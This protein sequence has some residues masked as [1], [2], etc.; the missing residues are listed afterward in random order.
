MAGPL[1]SPRA[2][3]LSPG[4]GGMRGGLCSLDLPQTHGHSGHGG[5]QRPQDLPSCSRQTLSAALGMFQFK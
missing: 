5:L 4:L 1:P 2:P 3:G